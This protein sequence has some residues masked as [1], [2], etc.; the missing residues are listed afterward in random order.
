MNG[1]SR[2]SSSLDLSILAKMRHPVATPPMEFLKPRTLKARQKTLAL[3][4]P[5]LSPVQDDLGNVPVSM[6]QD[7]RINGALIGLTERICTYFK[8]SRPVLIQRVIAAVFEEIYRREATA[9]LM[10]C[11]ELLEDP[12][13]ELSR[14]RANI[15]ALQPDAPDP[16]WVSDLND[17]IQ[18]NYERPDTLVL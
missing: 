12:Q 8:V 10:Q 1:F 5:C 3:L 16:N 4:L 7:P 14:A 2:P 17:Y 15:A 6:Q 18:N 11:D 13:S 9:V